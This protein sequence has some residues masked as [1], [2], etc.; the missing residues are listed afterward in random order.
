MSMKLKHPIPLIV[1]L[2]LSWVA[3]AFAQ[4]ATAPPSLSLQDCIAIALQQ[5]IDVLVGQN[6]LIGSKARETE[7]RSSY[8]P[9]IAVQGSK[10]LAKSGGPTLG[11]NGSSSLTVTQNFYDGGL[12]EVGVRS[13]RAALAQTTFGLDRTRQT[14]TF[15]VTR[16]YL[17]LLRTRQLADV[18]DVSVKYLEGQLALIQTRVQVGAAAPVDTLPVEAQLA[19][20]RVD[21]LSAKNDVLTAAVQLQNTMGL[22]PQPGFSIQETAEPS[23]TDIQPLEDFTA[24]ALAVRLEVQQSKA[25]VQAAQSSV[26]SA[27]IALRPRPNISGQFDQP[28]SGG[29]S[30]SMTITGSLVFDLFN[31][32][33]NRAA[34]DD[35][36]TS[37]WSVQFRQAQLEKDILSDVQQAYL[38]LTN[39]RERL[40]A[41]DLSLKAAQKN[42]DAQEGRYKQGVAIPLDLLNAQLAVVTAQ[43][44]AVQA[45]YDYYTSVAQL[46][47]ATGK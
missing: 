46:D 8:Y 13:A 6:S 26:D 22:S 34:Y 35:A 19:N 45:R 40:A 39:A 31:G 28:L 27:K 11:S 7:A 2:A 32:N 41:S 36:R 9:E 17:A 4:E 16:G 43:S 18:K 10:V 47:Y 1:I 24:I 15:N 38:N 42:F 20:A 14:V 25:S 33:R 5:Q 30:D 29:G 37:L 23:L 21:Q 12:R 3:P 44:N